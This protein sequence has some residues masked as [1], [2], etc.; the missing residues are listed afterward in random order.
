MSGQQA[1]HPLPA[2]HTPDRPS[3]HGLTPPDRSAPEDP[4][5]TC[6]VGLG[7]SPLGLD[8]DKAITAAQLLAHFVEL[9]GQLR[10]LVRSLLTIT[11]SPGRGS[12]RVE[13]TGV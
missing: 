10:N 13:I 8:R 11:I 7:R 6:L 4:T 3:R 5:S 12:E 1:N 9:D 2:V